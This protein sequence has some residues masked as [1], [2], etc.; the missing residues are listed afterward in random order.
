MDAAC[1]H[2]SLTV[3]WRREQDKITMWLEG[4]VMKTGDLSVPSS[5][6]RL[7]L[8][9]LKL[10]A[11]CASVSSLMLLFSCSVVSNPLQPHGLKHARLPCPS[12]FPTYPHLLSWKTDTVWENAFQ[13]RCAWC[14][15]GAPYLFIY[16]SLGLP[17]A[18]VATCRLSLVATSRVCSLA[19]VCGLL[20]VVA[21]L[22]EEHGFYGLQAQWSWCPVTPQHE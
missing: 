8:C 17:W 3:R 20:I 19:T 11:I 18:L 16:I 2:G 5:A 6:L 14:I 9:D 1:W 12:P 7:Q 10:H 21:S 4:R 13:E 15:V 22:I